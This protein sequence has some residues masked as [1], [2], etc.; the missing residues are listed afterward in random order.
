MGTENVIIF[1]VP[2]LFLQRCNSESPDV[3]VIKVSRWCLWSIW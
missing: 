2:F 3:Y 1:S